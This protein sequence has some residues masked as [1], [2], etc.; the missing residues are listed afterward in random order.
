MVLLLLS[1]TNSYSID[2]SDMKARMRRQRNRYM[3]FYATMSC[4]L[5]TLALQLTRVYA[6]CYITPVNGHVDIPDGTTSIDNIVHS[7]AALAWRL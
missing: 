1:T 5:I 6:G 3:S 2:A 4:V 7:L